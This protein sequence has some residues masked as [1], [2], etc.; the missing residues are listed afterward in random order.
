[1]KGGIEGRGDLRCVQWRGDREGRGVGVVVVVGDVDDEGVW[2]RLGVP[3]HLL[4][5]DIS[6]RPCT[7]STGSSRPC[8]M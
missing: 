7:C 3:V 8:Q 1:M 6:L 5:V 2:S 4:K